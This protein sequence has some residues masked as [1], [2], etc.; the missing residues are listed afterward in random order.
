MDFAVTFFPS[1][2]IRTLA[3]AAAKERDEEDVEGDSSQEFDVS[4]TREPGTVLSGSDADG[5]EGE[6]GRQFPEPVL[7]QRPTAASSSSSAGP[8][9]QRSSSSA[10]ELVSSQ[11]SA[12]SSQVNFC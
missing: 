4:Q 3:Q 5:E 2:R 8:A 7:T 12:N 11:T 1:G 10:A 6:W 9:I